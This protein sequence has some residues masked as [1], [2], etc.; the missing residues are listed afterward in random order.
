MMRARSASFAAIRS[1]FRYAARRHPE[2]AAVFNAGQM[3]AALPELPVP[4]ASRLAS[5]WGV[6]RA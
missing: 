1:L 3:M 5:I 4:F 2:H 6:V